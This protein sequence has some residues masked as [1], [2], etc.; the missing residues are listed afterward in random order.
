LNIDA[1]GGWQVWET[2]TTQVELMAGEHTITILSTAD[3]WNFNWF[4][5]ILDSAE[6]SVPVVDDTV[7]TTLQ[8]V[9]L[10]KTVVT[11][12]QEH[13]GTSGANAV[14]GDSNT[15]WSSE[16]SDYQWIYVDLGSSLE[17]SS[18]E[19]LWETAMASD[20]TIDVSD[21]AQNWT[22]VEWV[23]NNQDQINSFD[24]FATQARYVRIN[25][26][27]RATVWGFSLFELA[28]YAEQ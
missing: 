11:S 23:T 2:V 14:D 8:N 13:D 7:T 22:E 1:T 4:E 19:L 15:R 16:H 9:A 18:I 25:G 21:D 3:S 28:I 12:S 6:E 10:N 20:Y 17:V 5:L 24:N 26:L 27:T